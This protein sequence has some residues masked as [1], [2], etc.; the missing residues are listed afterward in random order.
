LT[1]DG[2]LWSKDWVRDP[3]STTWY[4]K[5][6]QIP[7]PRFQLSEVLVV[8][9]Y[10]L[11]DRVFACGSNGGVF[12]WSAALGWMDLTIPRGPTGSVVKLTAGPHSAV[13][14][15]GTGRVQ[16]MASSDGGQLWRRVVEPANNAGGWTAV[17][18]PPALPGAA[19]AATPQGVVAVVDGALWRR[20][21]D[22]A[23]WQSH[24]G[25]R[26]DRGA[27]VSGWLA[28]AHARWAPRPGFLGSLV[29]VHPRS[30]GGASLRVGRAMDLDARVAGGW[31]APRDVAPLAGTTLAAAGCAVA[32]VRGGDRPDLVLAYATRTAAGDETLAYRVGWGIDAEGAATGG[33]SPEKTLA[34]LPRNPAAP[35]GVEVQ[36]MDVAVAD[37]DGDGRPEI[38]VVYARAG[39]TTSRVF[40]RIGWDLDANGDP[41]GGWGEPIEIDGT[42]GPMRGLGVAVGDT[43]GQ[44]RPDL[45]VLT[46]EGSRTRYHILYGL[47]ARGQTLHGRVVHDVP[48][49]PGRGTVAGA[50]LVLADFTGSGQ[51]D[52]AIVGAEQVPGGLY[53][54]V[55]RLGRD[56]QKYM[57]TVEAWDAP[58]P[59]GE[60][61]ALVGRGV[62]A[63]L[64]DL[65][66]ALVAAR[67]A[68]SSRFSAAAA[69]HHA[70]IREAFALSVPRPDQ[71]LEGAA[72]VDQLAARTRDA[73]EPVALVDA[74]V[75]ARVGVPGTGGGASLGMRPL[76]AAPSFDQ[77]MY[78]PLLDLSQELLFPGAARVTPE[79]ATL[80]RTNPTFIEAFM[81]GLNHEFSRELLWREFPAERRATFFRRFW[82]GDTPDVPPLEAWD[83][84]RGLG[85]SAT[86]VGAADM[87]VLLIRGELLRRFPDTGISM[88]RAVWR[89]GRRVPDLST[90]APAPLLPRF[91][92]RLDPDMCFFGFDLRPHEA[93]G[94]RLDGGWFVVLRQP[95]S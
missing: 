15:P 34:Q 70:R 78:E 26:D 1:A 36:A 63:A 77:P 16:L 64:A 55:M 80:L 72:K 51:P 49:V 93:L 89:D 33:W 14:E 84:D 44:Y 83:P 46:D 40:V 7:R 18:A 37:L 4:W 17:A 94:D 43:T 73:Q 95:S 88:H 41:A 57:G 69:S 62:G 79:S 22:G 5:W 58:V 65:D 47:N 35:D 20:P 50:A 30:G 2:W 60:P 92:G 45:I 27:G 90:T 86:G 9:M 11:G 29:V 31:T 85:A 6:T 42:F 28:T 56:V 32:R 68:M 25:G 48:P 12:A 66:S 71:V 13:A 76:L 81:V 74:R 8:E 53:Q 19:V 3:Y 59:I 61:S 82:D 87:M 54:L 23:A 21:S 52:L 75:D 38:I 10:V 67:D 24:G 91:R 39:A